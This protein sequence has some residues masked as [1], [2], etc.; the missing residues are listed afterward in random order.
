MRNKDQ[1]LLENVY[2]TI[3]TDKNYFDLESQFKSGDVS[4]KVKAQELINNR[5]KEM[6]YNLGP[7][8]HGTN[9]KKF[10]EFDK[11][12]FNV[13]LAGSGFYFTND[14][15]YAKK[16][17][18][19]LIKVYLHLSNP[20]INDE[21][22]VLLNGKDINSGDGRWI[23]GGFPG[24]KKG[25][26]IFLVKNSNQIKLA[27]LFTYDDDRNLIPLSQRFDLSKNDIRY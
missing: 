20:V 27:N 15:E 22:G 1:V 19:I 16:Y 17:G 18:N 13:N 23:K 3:N 6:G 21:N 24:T 14:Q 5:A 9:S 8:W 2:K 25:Q 7:V 10:S 11:N 4:A 26:E 12:K